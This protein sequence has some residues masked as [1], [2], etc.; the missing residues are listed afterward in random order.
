MAYYD[1]YCEKCKKKFEIK[2]SLN[3][4][5]SWVRCPDCGGADI[6]R[7]YDGSVSAAVKGGTGGGLVSSGGGSSCS[8][9]TS[10]N[11]GSC[12]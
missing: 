10:G 1:Y 11:C 5:R 9:C 12:G 4:D 2:A 3:D 6:R 8:G 7:L